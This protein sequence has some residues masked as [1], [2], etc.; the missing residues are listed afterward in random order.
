MSRPCSRILDEPV[1]VL[2]LEDEDWGVGTLLFVMLHLIGWTVAGL[3]AAALG[4]G[5]LRAVK[6]GRPP[7]IVLHQ[8]WRLGLPLVPGPPPAPPPGGQ[9]Y[10][11]W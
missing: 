8:L 10:S 4:V 1:R 5:L 11:P 9:R 7:G 6:R 2:G 3:V